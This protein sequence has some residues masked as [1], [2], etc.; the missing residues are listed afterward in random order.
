LISLKAGHDL[1][2]T[3]PNWGHDSA[4]WVKQCQR[5]VELEER[6]SA[7]LDGTAEPAKPAEEVEF[8]MVCQCKRLYAAAAKK[9]QA[10]FKAQPSLADDRQAGWRYLAARC[11]V[12]AAC[13]QGADP[14]KLSDAERQ[15]LR[16]QGRAWLRAELARWALARDSAQQAV[17]M[18]K[19]LRSWLGDPAF[20]AVR[21]RLALTHLPQG[22]RTAWLQL[23]SEVAALSD[24]TAGGNRFIPVD[25]SN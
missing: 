15:A 21:D 19:T 7:A 24:E 23:W 1:G 18:R 17:A 25:T 13:D 12:L 22:E 4:K 2:V 6:L 11:A 3:L 5:F 16:D 14:A 10:A 8:A 9:Y 20:A